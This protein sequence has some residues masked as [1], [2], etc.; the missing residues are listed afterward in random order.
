MRTNQSIQKVFCPEAPRIMLILNPAAGRGRAFHRLSEISRAFE[1][2]GCKVTTFITQKRG[3]ASRFVM[4]HGADFHRIVCLG[5]DGTLNE[6]ASGIARSGLSVPVGYIPGGSAND[7]ARS[8]RLSRDISVAVHEILYSSG[9]QTDIGKLNTR[10]FVY[11]A[12]FGAFTRTSYTTPQALKNTLGYAAYLLS[13]IRD[14]STIKAEH[15]RITADSEVHEGNYLFGAI[16]NTL[17]IG[18]MISLP[19]KFV[20]MDDGVF[21][22]LLIRM[23]DTILEWPMLLSSLANRDLSCKDIDFFHSGKLMMEAEKPLDWTLDGEYACEGPTIRVEN[24]HRFLTLA[25]NEPSYSHQN[26]SVE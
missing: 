16:C 22:V 4:E 18:R 25:A 17:S 20:A 1:S 11:V 19:T 6:V 3:D 26:S 8:H 10:Y 24:L 21:E 14:I 12:A 9:K 23:P 7:F 13:G 15:I 5:G 2:A